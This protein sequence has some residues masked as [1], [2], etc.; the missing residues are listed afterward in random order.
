MSRYSQDEVV[1]R[2]QGV[3][4]VSS[5][6]A[7]FWPVPVFAQFVLRTASLA[8]FSVTRLRWAEQCGHRAQTSIQGLGGPQTLL[9]AVVLHS[10][11]SNLTGPSRSIES[12]ARLVRAETRSELG[13]QTTV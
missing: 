12:R 8:E 1:T 5:A 7:A 11:I 9:C 10:T 2:Q 4:A 6:G 13:C 3:A